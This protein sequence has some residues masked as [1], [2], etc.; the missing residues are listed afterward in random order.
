[1]KPNLCNGKSV[2]QLFC[3]AQLHT[4]KEFNQNQKGKTKT[5]RLSAETCIEE[6]K[7]N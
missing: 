4:R 5:I 6:N 2:A 7:N 3:F 1:M